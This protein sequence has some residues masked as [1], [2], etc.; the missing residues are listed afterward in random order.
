MGLMANIICK[1]AGIAGLS[2]ATYDATKKAKVFSKVGA[3]NAAADTFEKVIATKRTMEVASATTNAMQSK[4]AELRTSN[5]VIPFIARIKGYFKGFFK[6]AGENIVP[7]S[8]SAMALGG[9]KRVQKFGA[10]GLAAY[11]VYMILKEGFGVGKT[12]PMD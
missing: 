8:F 4:V 12:S 10:I 9:G 5:P 11:S 7:I 3:Q 2:L 1:T 6:S